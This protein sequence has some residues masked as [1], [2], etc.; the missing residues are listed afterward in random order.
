M[1]PEEKYDL[2]VRNTQE[3]VGDDELKKILKKRDLKVYL[4]TEISGKPHIGYFVVAMKIKDFFHYLAKH[5]I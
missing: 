3:I 2:I 4:G 5:F 1:T